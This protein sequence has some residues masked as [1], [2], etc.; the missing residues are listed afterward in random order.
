MSNTARLACLAGVTV[1]LIATGVTVVILGSRSSPSER[2]PQALVPPRHQEAELMGWS[3]SGG[4]WRAMTMGMGAARALHK[5]GVLNDTRLR[6]VGSNSGGAWFLTQF[7]YSA[8]FYDDVTGDHDMKA[9]VTGWM[10]SQRPLL[11]ATLEDQLMDVSEWLAGYPPLTSFMRAAIKLLNG[12]VRTPSVLRTFCALSDKCVQFVSLATNGLTLAAGAQGSWSRYI[13]EMLQLYDGQITSKLASTADRTGG[14]LRPDLL[15]Q[16][17]NMSSSLVTLSAHQHMPVLSHILGLNG[18]HTEHLSFPVAYRVPGT[19]EGAAERAGLLASEPVQQLGAYSYAYLDRSGGVGELVRRLLQPGERAETLVNATAPFYPTTPPIWHVASVSSAAGA[20]AGSIEW[21]QK[22]LYESQGSA[23]D[24]AAAAE[25]ERIRHMNIAAG[26]EKGLGRQPAAGDEASAS[27]VDWM[28]AP[29]AALEKAGA[30]GTGGTEP[31]VPRERVPP[32]ERDANQST[33]DDHLDAT[34]AVQELVEA[35]LGRNVSLSSDCARVLDEHCRH[36]DITWEGMLHIVPCFEGAVAECSGDLLQFLADLAICGLDEA[37]AR[38]PEEGLAVVEE[39]FLERGCDFPHTRLADGA[40]SDNTAAA[41]AV[42]ALQRKGGRR[43]PLRF[44]V[45]SSY[46][47]SVP[48]DP[49]ACIASISDVAM[50]FGDAAGAGNLVGTPAQQVFA[51]SWIDVRHALRRL[52]GTEGVLHTSF[53]TTTVANEYYGVVAGSP[54]DILLLH[55]AA[56]APVTLGISSTDVQ[57]DALGNFGKD[58][59][60]EPVVELVKEFYGGASTPDDA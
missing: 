2:S 25:A 18:E 7:T 28:R 12:L 30:N 19:A 4:G 21:V 27:W 54:I 6:V 51:A 20:A 11:A 22:I 1:T 14:L 42:G 44:I 23:E 26:L 49:D 16:M 29:R 39:N 59:A 55:G 48:L 60:S 45:S 36:V 35:I 9:V 57:I 52:E 31:P 32:A 37:A 17:S 3:I 46:S 13:G 34:D 53:S 58:V 41:Q 33:V 10:D 24:A 5:A 40:Y 47:C 15:F 8:Q 38:T 50:L 56:D 43:A